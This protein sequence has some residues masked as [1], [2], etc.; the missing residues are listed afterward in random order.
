KDSAKEYSEK[1]ES[2]ALYFYKSLL[3][4]LLVSIL[5]SGDI[6]D[7]INAYDK[8]ILDEDEE[9]L[10]QDEKKFEENINKKYEY[11]EDPEGKLNILRSEISMDILTR[12]KEDELGIY[13]LDLPTG[14][15]KTLLSLRYGVNQMNYQG[16]E[17]FFYVTSFLSVLEQNASEMRE[18][19]NNDDF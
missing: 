6:K 8:V 17:R 2:E 16:K 12:S 14:A 11:L 3:T 9:K 7:T 4:R 18:I 19:L 10:G 1:K 15:G 5:K 13:K